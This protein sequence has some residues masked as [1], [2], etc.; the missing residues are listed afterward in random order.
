MRDRRK[1]AQFARQRIQRSGVG[2]FRPHHERVRERIAVE[3]GDDLGETLRRLQFLQRLLARYEANLAHARF[4]L[5]PGAER[6]G[7]GAPGIGAQEHREL[8]LE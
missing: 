8:R 5:Q 1:R 3:R 2:G 7:V 4:A 6:V